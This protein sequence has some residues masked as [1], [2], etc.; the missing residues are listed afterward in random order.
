MKE[1]LPIRQ[2]VFLVHGEEPAVAGLRDRLSAFLPAARVLAPNLDDT[3]ELTSSGARLL[4]SEQPRRLELARVGKPDW[5]ND[6][7]KL[8]LD[9]NDTLDKTAD[10]RARAV[11]I[12][13]LR[14]ALEPSR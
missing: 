5:H 1:R 9:I 14:K 3:F 2:D 10:E 11:V 4:R 6:V 13:R 12:R 7:S 8:M